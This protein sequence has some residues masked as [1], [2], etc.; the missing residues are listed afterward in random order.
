[1]LL[2]DGRL[3]GF[4][5]N[6]HGQVGVPIADASAESKYVD[7]PAPVAHLSGTTGADAVKHIAGGDE[8]SVALTRSGDVFVWGRGQYGQ[9][10]LGE[11]RAG[12]L[13]APTKVP[14]LPAIQSLYTGPNQVFAVEFTDG[15]SS[16]C[17]CGLND[18]RLNELVCV[19]LSCQ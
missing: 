10:G 14:D 5:D 16:C 19:T 12:P 9:L 15:T 3:F 6:T 17:C 13:D 11:A 1:M 18:V 8:F 4:G 7:A 2:Q